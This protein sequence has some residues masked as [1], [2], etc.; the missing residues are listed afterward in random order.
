MQKV[1]FVGFLFSVFNYLGS[2]VNLHEK[3]I[4]QHHDAVDMLNRRYDALMESITGEKRKKP[5]KQ[6]DARV[7]PEVQAGIDLFNRLFRKHK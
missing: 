6:G 5:I 1:C 2:I 7:T 4:S 3:S